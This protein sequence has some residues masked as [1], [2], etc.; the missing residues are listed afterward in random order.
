ML[1]IQSWWHKR[2]IDDERAALIKVY[3]RE[4]SARDYY[5]T[6]LVSRVRLRLIVPDAEDGGFW[7]LRIGPDDTSWPDQLFEPGPSEDEM[8]TAPHTGD[9]DRIAHPA[10]EAHESETSSAASTSETS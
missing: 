8:A 5:P 3:P 10:A 7:H 2:L 6:T 1:E 4:V 9:A